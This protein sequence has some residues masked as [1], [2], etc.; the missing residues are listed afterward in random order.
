MVTPDQLPSTRPSPCPSPA[1]IDMTTSNVRLLAGKKAS[2]DPFIRRS[3]SVDASSTASSSTRTPSRG[4]GTR[5]ISIEFP[6]ASDINACSIDVSVK[7]KSGGWR[8]LNRIS[9]SRLGSPLSRNHYGSG[10]RGPDGRR[11]VS[12][13]RGYQRRRHLWSDSDGDIQHT[14]RDRRIESADARHVISDLNT[15]RAPTWPEG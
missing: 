1:P 4:G 15:A 10:S 9:A 2:T 8:I 11:S 7:Y 3:C 5:Q 6:V 13:S 12:S 14:T